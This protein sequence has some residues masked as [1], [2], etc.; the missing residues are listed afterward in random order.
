MG[1]S[2][3]SAP[4]PS[5]PN[6]HLETGLVATSY[7]KERQALERLLGSGEFHRSPNLEKILTYLC[8]QYFLG[9]GNQVKEYTVA[10]EA[11]DRR[12]DFDPKRDSIVRVEM[13][14]LRRRLKEYY[15]GRGAEDLVRITIPDK[16]YVPEFVS[17]QPGIALRETAVE[18]AAS[19]AV[20]LEPAWLRVRGKPAGKNPAVTVAGLIVLLIAGIYWSQ[21]GKPEV[22]PVPTATVNSASM[23]LNAS[24][25]ESRISSWAGGGGEFR[26]LAGHAKG[27]YPDR[28]G[29]VWQGDDFFTGGRPVAVEGEVRAR[30]M[31]P[32][33]FA[34]MREGDFSY[35]IPLSP[36][37]YELTLY[38]AETSFGEGNV[39]GGGETTRQFHVH[40]NGKNVLTNFDV[41]A[42]AHDPNAATAR[43]FKDG[44]PCGSGEASLRCPA[45]PRSR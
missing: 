42:D 8:K 38:F 41:L 34:N 15:A 3:H 40:I 9:Q 13:H 23:A 2:P 20:G 37:A 6:S 21:R 31:D 35:E 14:R 1:L 30:G 18:V 44:K 45:A 32:N 28:Y 39:F 22:V 26:I 19:P 33:L 27:R 24:A 17:V 25:G 11:L 36:G 43:V 5:D 7:A 12:E 10:T 4:L 29:V 16:S